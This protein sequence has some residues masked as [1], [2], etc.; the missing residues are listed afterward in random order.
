MEA[1]L[2]MRRPHRGNVKIT[3]FFLSCIDYKRSH[4]DGHKQLENIPA[5]KRPYSH[6]NYARG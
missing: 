3:L 5:S 4:F 6:K 2:I 1:E